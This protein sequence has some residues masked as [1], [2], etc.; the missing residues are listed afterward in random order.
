MIKQPYETNECLPL[1]HIICKNK[2]E[3]D[4]RL[5]KAKSRKLKKNMGENLSD[6]VFDKFLTK[7]E[8]FIKN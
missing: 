2:L 6:L 3:G 8:L 7:C 5:I 4:N 1:A